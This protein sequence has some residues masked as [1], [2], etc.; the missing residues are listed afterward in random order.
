MKSPYSEVDAGIM[1]AKLT[2]LSYHKDNLLPT[3][4]DLAEHSNGLDIAREAVSLLRSEAND[5]LW[6]ATWLYAMTVGLSVE[7]AVIWANE[8]R[9]RMERVWEA[10]K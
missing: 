5:A 9:H 2:T 1:L 3:Y 7:G 8:M 6:R 4:A 10:A